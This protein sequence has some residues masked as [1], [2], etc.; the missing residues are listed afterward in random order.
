MLEFGLHLDYLQVF[1]KIDHDSFSHLY[2]P[3]IAAK[4]L[5]KSTYYK[6]WFGQDFSAKFISFIGKAFQWKKCVTWEVVYEE[7]FI[8]S[9][10]AAWNYFWSTCIFQINSQIIVQ[11]VLYHLYKQISYSK[12]F[13]ELAFSVLS[14]FTWKAI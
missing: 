10:L 7:H 1:T 12:L 14:F 5:A 3:G 8:I 9:S 6:K 2:Y 4:D 13:A 11:S